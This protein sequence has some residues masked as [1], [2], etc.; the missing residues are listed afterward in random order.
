MA[1]IFQFPTRPAERAGQSTRPPLAG[2]D[3]PWREL[4]GNPIVQALYRLFIA[5][6][7]CTWPVLRW[8]VG[9]DLL[10]QLLRFAFIG[11]LSG[12]AAL[13]HML[14]IGVLAYLVLY[15]PPLPRN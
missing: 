2:L 6:V 10:I 11:G 12:F 5:F 4:W 8:F 15:V 9:M 14:V 7:A 1:R 13:M 3:H